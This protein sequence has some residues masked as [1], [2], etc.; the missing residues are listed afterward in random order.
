MPAQKKSKRGKRT[1]TRPARAAYW[2]RGGPAASK[3]RNLMRHGRT[4]DLRTLVW[5]RGMAFDAA[6]AEWVSSGKG[7]FKGMLPTATTVRA[8]LRRRG[9]AL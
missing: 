5:H 4:L 9:V 1:D 8:V 7:R 2:A 6:F 3:V